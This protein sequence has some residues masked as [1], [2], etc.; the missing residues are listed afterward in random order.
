MSKS[1]FQKFLAIEVTSRVQEIS[2]RRIRAEYFKTKEWYNFP[3][4]TLLQKVGDKAVFSVIPL[5]YRDYTPRCTPADTLPF[6]ENK[7]FMHILWNKKH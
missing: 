1:D 3:Q 6:L 7:T 2:F 5:K 4:T